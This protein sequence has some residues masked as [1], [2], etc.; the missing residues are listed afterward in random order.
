MDK[1]EYSVI[2]FDLGN[3]LIP[4]DYNISF[5]KLEKIEAGL[6]QKFLDRYMGNYKTHRSFERGTITDDEFLNIMLGYVDNKIDKWT[7]IDVY[8][9]IF[10]VNEE[11]VALLPQLK[12][13]Y[14]LVLLSNTNSI[15][16]K[17]GWNECGFLV[18]FDKLILSHKVGAVKP[19]EKIY[20]AVEAFTR[21]SP[22]QHIF[23]DDILDYV[24]GAKKIGW[25][26]VQFTG[27]SQLVKDLKERKII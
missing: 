20:K 23:I 9:K 26:A 8:S 14:K 18:H 3:V 17:Y 11:V 27:Y 4:F 15:H 1:R 5:D 10:E 7:M 6:G 25:D 21:T 19:E 2:V 13:K 24:Q 12:N 16:Q 22:A